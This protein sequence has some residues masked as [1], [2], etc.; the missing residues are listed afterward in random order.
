MFTLI[1]SRITK[2]QMNALKKLRKWCYVTN[3]EDSK[4]IM[5]LN[6]IELRGLPN[7]E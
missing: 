5:G 7:Y 4:S 2:Y 6:I 3:Y 1:T